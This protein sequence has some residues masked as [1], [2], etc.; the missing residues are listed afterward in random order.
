MD[1]KKKLIIIISSIA[2]VLVATG[3]ILAI[4]LGGNKGKNENTVEMM[5]ANS[6]KTIATATAD[7][8]VTDGGIKVLGYKQI[9]EIGEGETVIREITAELNSTQELK[10]KETVQTVTEYNRDNLIT[11]SFEEFMYKTYNYSDGTLTATVSKDR[12]DNVLGYN[13]VANSDG[14]LTAKFENSLIKEFT[15][16]FTMED[17]KVLTMVSTYQ[18]KE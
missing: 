1:K 10:E 14:T 16:T 3:I 11:F 5:V 18:Y 15:F 8:S 12:V 4:E 17:G 9:V 2:A 7:V 6:E 13:L